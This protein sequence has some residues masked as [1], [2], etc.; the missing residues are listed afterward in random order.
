MIGLRS[1][2]GGGHVKKDDESAPEETLIRSAQEFRDSMQ[3]LYEL[4]ALV[5]ESADQLDDL[6]ASFERRMLLAHP[7]VA[8]PGALH[9]RLKAAIEDAVKRASAVRQEL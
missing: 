4:V 8:D 5:D 3:A 9:D 2:A 6:K 7:S 1:Q